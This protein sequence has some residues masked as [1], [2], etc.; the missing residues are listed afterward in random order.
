[1]SKPLN[2][3]Q[4]YLLSQI[5]HHPEGIPSNHIRD[6]FGFAVSYHDPDMASLRRRRLI[7]C[8]ER[9]NRVVSRTLHWTGVTFAPRA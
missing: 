6:L 2:D 9:V 8:Q 5:P 3:R 4:S 1:M 7:Y